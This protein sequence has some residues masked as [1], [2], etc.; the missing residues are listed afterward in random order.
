MKTIPVEV[1]D[2]EL[3]RPIVG[4]FKA[5]RELEAFAHEFLIERV[6][7]AHRDG[8]A[9][10]RGCREMHRTCIEDEGDMV[11]RDYYE[12]SRFSEFNVDGEAEFTAI[13]I[14]GHGGIF[15]FQLGS[16]TEKRAHGNWLEGNDKL[17]QVNVCWFS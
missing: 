8:D 3:P 6:D 15:Y 10:F 5:S 2:G 12:I 16:D 13:V 1:F 17:S 14:S 9:R 11:S 4:A 7:V